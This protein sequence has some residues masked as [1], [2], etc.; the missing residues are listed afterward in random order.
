MKTQIFKVLVALVMAISL[1]GCAAIFGSTP[2]SGIELSEDSFPLIIGETQR[3]Y[4]AVRPEGAATD[5]LSWTSRDPAIATVDANGSVTGIA[6]GT[7]IITVSARN[8]EVSATCGVVV[9]KGFPV[10]DIALDRNSLGMKVNESYQFSPVITPSFARDRTLTWTTSDDA[11]VRPITSEPGKVF[12][13]GPGTATI[14]ATSGNGKVAQCV[15][16]V[17]N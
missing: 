3:V 9:V 16:T 7:T 11:V 2:V 5:G 1:A 8:G 15:V 6:E 4:A 12:A 10:E 14:K 17:T 13:V